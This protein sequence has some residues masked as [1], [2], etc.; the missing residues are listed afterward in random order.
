MDAD[1]REDDDEEVGVDAIAGRQTASLMRTSHRR[2]VKSRI[3]TVNL[4]MQ[5]PFQQQRQT[6][7][8]DSNYYCNISDNGFS[9]HRAELK[10]NDDDNGED[11]FYENCNDWTRGKNCDTMTATERV[12]NGANSPA[13]GSSDSDDYFDVEDC[14]YVNV[15]C[16]EHSTKRTAELNNNN[17]NN[18]FE[19]ELI[20]NDKVDVAKSLHSC[21][22]I[23]KELSA[24]LSNKSDDSQ[25]S[26][27]WD[28]CKIR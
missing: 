24:S 23:H 19:N 22:L 4:S 26:S 25:V 11:T 7:E 20:D 17:N 12:I 1:N 28:C 5:P 8:V 9:Y 6:S 16:L 21:Q 14:D 13:G 15:P 18:K 2:A 3:R 27:L 10:N